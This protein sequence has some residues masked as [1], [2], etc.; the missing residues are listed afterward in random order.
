MNALKAQVK[1]GRLSLDIPTEL[2][3]GAVVELLPRPVEEPKKQLLWE[4]IK[5]LYPD[6]WVVMVEL[7]FNESKQVIGGFVFDH[8]KSR[9]ALSPRIKQELAGMERAVFYTGEA[10][11]R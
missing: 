10:R 4:E 9:K 8:S 1:N 7:L 3:E 11:V 6:E 2:P 5:A